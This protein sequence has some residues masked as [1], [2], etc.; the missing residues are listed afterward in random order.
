MFAK[1]AISRTWRRRLWPWMRRSGVRRVVTL[2]GGSLACALIACCLPLIVLTITSGGRNASGTAT[3]VRGREAVGSPAV[4]AVTAT[5]P[6]PTPTRRATR[7]MAPTRI[8]ALSA[9]ATPDPAAADEVLGTVVAILDGDTI[10]VDIV[11]QVYP[12]RYI[13]IDAPERDA[14]CGPQAAQANADL[15]AGREVRL[16]RDRSH[17]DRFDRLL[18]YVYVADVFVNAELIRQGYA[19]SRR[20]APDTAQLA[21]LDAIE[22]EVR[23]ANLNCY[24]LGVFGAP[25]VAAA[26]ADTQS[27]AAVVVEP[28]PVSPAPPTEAPLAT[29][30]APTL[31][32]PTP[33]PP[34][35]EPPTAPPVVIAPPTQAPAPS[36]C[37][38]S[39][40]TVCISPPPPDLDCGDIPYRRFAVVGSDPHRFDGDNDGVGCESD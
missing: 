39:Y 14:T 33:E 11:G 31:P 4:A 18:R 2:V 23:G 29:A 36:N 21:T 16:V 10:E 34:T 20:Y 3:E 9:T 8:V 27:R 30:E 12:V 38:P 24:A 13:G 28:A 6:G 32:A 1:D 5:A 7:T 19:E 15:V 22:A 40:P 25:A 37:D 26:T 35:A 17:T